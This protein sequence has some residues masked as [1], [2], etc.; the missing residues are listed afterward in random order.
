MSSSEEM[1]GRIRLNKGRDVISSKRFCLATL[2]LLSLC[3]V[4]LVGQQRSATPAGIERILMRRG[5][6]DRHKVALKEAAMRA[7]AEATSVPVALSAAPFQ[8][9]SGDYVTASGMLG[10]SSDVSPMGAI[11]VVSPSGRVGSLPIPVS[12]VPTSIAVDAVR[13]RVVVASVFSI[14]IIDLPSGSARR[15][16]GFNYASG[17][18]IA[19]N[20]DIFVADLGRDFFGATPDGG[21]Y[22]IDPELL[23][24]RRVAANHPWITP[25]SLD[26][27][28]D[29]KLLVLDSA[30]GPP[31][32]D[33]SLNFD[34]IFSIDPNSEAVTTV[35]QGPGII[36]TALGASS[37]D[38]LWVAT[39]SSTGKVDPKLGTFTEY[40]DYMFLFADG[41][42]VDASG[43][44]I[45]TDGGSFAPPRYHA[46]DRIRNPSLS[47]QCDLGIVAECGLVP[48]ASGLDIVP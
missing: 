23:S 43:D 38:S 29:G 11:L 4:P 32:G 7:R 35:Y 12:I 36:G 39:V 15:L 26:F 48:G 47:G 13:R 44:L 1:M 37:D 5:A 45:V 40:C 2:S 41:I 33:F 42:Q 21:I 24:R 30:A 6:V 8:F 25:A 28:R 31:I 27:D 3:T 22:R 34:A 9:A 16:S 46:I 14:V 20:G 17:V 19:G 18:A 10:P